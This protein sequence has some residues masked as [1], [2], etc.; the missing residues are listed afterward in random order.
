MSRNYSQI[1]IA[2]FLLININLTAQINFVEDTT[3]PFEGVNESDVVFADIDG[4]ND[5]DVLISGTNASNVKVTNLYLNDGFGGY[6]LVAGTPFPGLDYSDAAFADIDGDNDLDLIISGRVTNPNIGIT[7]LYTN[8]GIGNFTEVVVTPFDPLWQST[9]DFADVDGDN[10]LDVL[11]TGTITNTQYVTKLYTNDGSGVFTE[12]IGTPFIPV[13]FGDSEFADVDGDNDLDVLITGTGGT[14]SVSIASRLYSNDGFGN[15]TLVIGTPFQDVYDGSVDFADID[16]DNDLDVLITGVDGSPSSASVHLYTN[17]GNGVFT[18]VTGIPFPPVYSSS[19]AFADMEG[20]NDQDV[21]ISGATAAG[22]EEVFSNDGSG[23]FIN[24]GCLDLD[25]V[26]AGS[27][28]FADVDND[29]DLDLIITGNS[30]LSPWTARLYLNESQAGGS[31]GAFI[32][33]WETGVA[34]QNITIPTFAGETYNYNVDWG[35]GNTTTGATGNTSHIYAAAGTHQIS[36]TGVFPRIHFDTA[37]ISMQNAIKSIDQWGCNQWT[38]MVRSF[39]DCKSLVVNAIDIPN[40]TNVTDVAAMFMNA[41]ALGGGT[42]NWNWDTSTITDMNTMFYNTTNF[43]Q[44]IGSW[45]TS[46]VIRMSSMF[47][48][49]GFNQ[50]I[51]TWNTS[52]VTNMSTMFQNATSF[53]QP[54]NNWDTGMVTTM[55]AMFDTATSFNQPLSNWDTSSLIQMGAMFQSASQFNQDISAW[56]ISNVTTLSNTFRG[57]SVFNQPIGT[58]DTSSVTYLDGTFRDAVSFDQDLGNWNVN[59]VQYMYDTF[60]GVTLSTPNYDSILISWDAQALLPLIGFNSLQA[61]NS[62]YCAGEAARANMITSDG[63]QILDAGKAGATIIDLP[64][65]TAEALYVLPPIT[66]TGL[67]GTEQYF[68]GPNGTGTPYN[69][70]DIIQFADLASY[71]VTLYIYD[72]LPATCTSEESFQLTLT[73]GCEFITTWQTTTANESITIPTTGAG[74]NYNVDWG[75]GNITTG[76]AGDASHTYVTAGNHQVTISGT[77]PR[78]FFGASTAANRPKIISI[79]QWGC[80]PWTSM[81]DAFK[82]CAN[83]IVNATDIPNLN[84]VTSMREMFSGATSLGGGS[85]NW[86]WSTGNVTTMESLFYEATNFNK[87]ISTWDMSSVTTTGAMFMFAT[88]FN[89]NIGNWDV[90]NVL[91][92][93]YMFYEALTFNQN[94]DGWNVGN[95]TDMSSMFHNATSFN[96]TIGNWNVGKVALMTS[97]FRGASVFNQPIGNWDTSSVT[98]TNAMFM[99][100]IAFNQDIGNWNVSN[101]EFMQGMFQYASVFNQNIGNW[102]TGSATSMTGMFNGASAFN[103]DIGNWDTSSVWTFTLMFMDAVSFD[104]DL[105]NWNVSSLNT[106]NSMFTRV[107]LSTANY[108]SLLI[109]WDAQNLNASVGFDGG[110]SKYCA[111]EA[112]RTNM[113]TTDSWN[114]TDGGFAG[115]A[116]NDLADQTATNSFTLPAITGTNL[117][118]NQAYYTGPGGTGAMYNAGDVINY[119]DFPS[120]P[121]TLYIYQSYSPSCN[122]EQDFLLT[123]EDPA[124]AF[125]TTWQTTTANESIAIPINGTIGTIDWGDGTITNDGSTAHTYVAAGTYQISVSGQLT[126]YNYNAVSVPKILSVEQWGCSQWVSMGFGGCVNLVVNALDTPDL[127]NATSLGA[128][129]NNCTALGGGTG[130]WNWDTS[131]ITDMSYMF[132]NATNFNQNIGS[133]NTASVTNMRDMF[134]GA[135]SF[136]QNIGALNTANVLNMRNMFQNASSFNQDIGTWNTSNVTSMFGM[137]QEATSFNENIGNWDTG[138][139]TIMRSMFEG[140]INFNQNIGAWNTSSVTIMTA[141]FYGASSFNQDNGGWDTSNVTSMLAMFYEA[142]SF[143]QDLGN[144][145]VENLVDASNMFLEVTL[146][147]QNYDSLLIGWD[148]QNLNPNVSFHG[149]FSQYCAGEAARANMISSDNWNIQDGGFAG[150]TIIDLADQTTIDSF[151]FPAITGTNLSGAEAYYTGPGGTGTSYSAG[152]VINYADLPAY[153]ATLY[154]YDSVYP[155]CSAEQDFLLTIT[156]TLDAF[157]TTWKTDNPGTSNNNQIT[158]PTNGGGYNYTVDWGDGNVTTGH[159]GDA[160]HTYATPGT[161]TVKITGDFPS[162]FFNDGGDKEK[163][164][165]I[166]QWGNNPWVSMNA[167][168]YGCINLQGNFTDSPDLS[169]VSNMALMFWDASSFNHPIGNWDVSNVTDMEFMFTNAT[170][171]N[172]DISTWNVSNVTNMEA[173]FWGASSFNQ[174]IGAWNVGMV[175]DM[176]AMFYDAISFNQNLNAWD[177]GSVTEMEFM[178]RGAEVFNQPLGNWNVSNVITMRGMFNIATVFNQPLGAWDVSSVTDMAYMFAIASAFNQDIGLWNVANVTDME[179]MFNATPF[180]YNIGAWNVANVNNMRYMFMLASAFNQDIGAWNVANVTDME[181]MFAWAYAFDQ[182]L[183]NWNVSNLT[184]ATDM[185]LEATLSIPNYDSLLIGWDAQNLLSTVNFHGGFSKYCLG[186]AA[187]ANM[188]ASD[189]WTIVDGGFAGATIVDLIDQNVVDSFTFPAIT[190]T[191]LSGT[192]TYYTGMGG[193][194]DVYHAGDVIN[195]ADFPSYPVTIYIYDSVSPGCNDEQDFLLTITCSTI[196]YAD[197]DGDGFGDATNSIQ[198]CTAPVG[199]IADNTDCDDTNNTVYPGAPELCDGLDN[200]CDGVI[201]PDEIDDDGDGYSECQGDCDDT[202]ATVYPTAPELCDGLD[203]NCDGTIDEGVTITY[204]ADTDGDGYGDASDTVQAC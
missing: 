22:Y 161:Y 83:V 64:D 26:T 115:G 106:A 9:I 33:T 174:D 78:I 54:L 153:P 159:T 31:N 110:L 188:I 149:G 146:S 152:T 97:M 100:A 79:D 48:F 61:G 53:N 92:M 157:I 164:L 32:T 71:P 49:S 125:I 144:W 42:G 108:D 128:A 129:F 148:V 167:A 170:A 169:N 94:I 178:F 201:P 117:L 25:G 113:I 88:S 87:D 186:E 29:S 193:T 10:D 104:Q 184:N 191:N 14:F 28:A 162:I 44:A 69:A 65:P 55:Y 105:G 89:Q 101:V 52:M 16:G 187:R 181:A 166:E 203:N 75:D 189:G 39:K 91:Q 60:H 18:E 142:V 134:N 183:G 90:S 74:Y 11:L 168:F 122:S 139:V 133:W 13:G 4:D 177:V 95:V 38:S 197:T 141:M 160:T 154:I 200:N 96:Q 185:F 140:A 5:L 138:N 17:D 59:S 98:S 21:F 70:G 136:N 46:N 40:F 43:N 202:N 163:I 116:V 179:A 124:C 30:A 198:S 99:E 68:T 176:S 165:T 15:Y 82:G 192:E 195:Y 84:N 143:D 1:T 194:G 6:A 121:I 34:N 24:V 63:L 3:V 67:S 132:L 50:N 158:I 137:F 175:T 27:I 173:M 81:R 114:I 19:V 7:K 155:G 126:G 156:S 112:A 2:L 103:Q 57:A 73:A 123:I 171:F 111:G 58:W 131:T 23:N 190:G 56:N 35:D 119:A 45:D 37:S 51:N 86:D 77:F 107:T 150:S 109:G 85:G 93:S 102:N 130:N 72:G 80:N 151:T 127:S 147:T 76:V 47:Q 62:K 145:N 36:I 120:Y 135:S 41:T 204:Y 118:G 182:D 199:Y 12:V 180:N 8:D 172:H 66:G 196:W 20:D